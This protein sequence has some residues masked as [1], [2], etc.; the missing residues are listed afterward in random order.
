[1]MDESFFFYYEETDWCYRFA[2]AGWKALFNPEAVITHIGGGG[3]S[4]AKA[5]QKSFVQ[6]QKSC[7]I[8]LRKN[9]GP[10]YAL[11][12]R[13]ILT[14]AFIARSVV[15]SILCLKRKLAGGDFHEHFKHQTD[16]AA[17]VRFLL[18]GIEP[19]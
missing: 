17:A 15:W 19:D 9:K 3:Q 5:R 10:V 18:F 1:V 16:S 2:K 4:S 13:T 12:G 8:Y 6:R 7:M 14:V 11:A